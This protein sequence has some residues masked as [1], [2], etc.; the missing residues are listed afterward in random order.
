M[1]KAMPFEE[2]CPHPQPS[3]QVTQ[4]VSASITQTFKGTQAPNILSCSQAKKPASPPLACRGGLGEAL[5]NTPRHSFPSQ[6]RAASGMW[7]WI[8]CLLLSHTSYRRIT[9]FC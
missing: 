3:L 2:T 1:M 4:E 5:Y 9:Y 6:E 7:D 8:G